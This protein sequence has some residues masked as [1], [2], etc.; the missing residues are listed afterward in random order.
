MCWVWF[1]KTVWFKVQALKILWV[2]LS[3][4]I[5]KLEFDYG[6]KEWLAADIQATGSES[7]M[8]V[9]QDNLP[10]TIMQNWSC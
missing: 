8:G 9:V 10:Y 7:L 6:L 4:A 1:Q 3:S 2:A 5:L